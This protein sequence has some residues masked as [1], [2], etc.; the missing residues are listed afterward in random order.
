[1]SV[2]VFRNSILIALLMFSVESLADLRCGNQLVQIGD[3]FSEVLDICGEP[4]AT[5]QTGTRYVSVEQK[6]GQ[7][8]QTT[9]SGQIIQY[10]DNGVATAGAEYTEAI[11]TEMWIYKPGQ[12]QLKRIL[13]FE[14]G[15]LV[16]VEYGDRS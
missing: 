10:D 9:Q 12:R 11:H 4:Y 6:Y 7:R 2:S 5:Y 1:M 14:N 8:Y 15:F 13:Y 16:R 3:D